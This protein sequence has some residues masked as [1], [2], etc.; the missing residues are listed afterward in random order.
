LP[1]RDARPSHI[2]AVGAEPPKDALDLIFE[3]LRNVARLA[4]AVFP[5]RPHDGPA[6]QTAAMQLQYGNKLPEQ[7]RIFA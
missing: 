1:D 6:A 4:N 7:T 5:H 2:A 3:F